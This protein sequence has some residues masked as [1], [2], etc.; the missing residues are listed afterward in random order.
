MAGILGNDSSLTSKA[1]E[2]AKA[3]VGEA[4]QEE[5]SVPTAQILL[6]DLKLRGINPK[7]GLLGIAEAQKQG[8]LKMWRK[9]NT[10]MAVVKISPIVARVHFFTVDQEPQFQ[11]LVK[12][13]LGSLVKSG[14]KVIYDRVADPHIIR[15][16][17]AAGAHIVPSDTPNMKLKAFI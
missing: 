14:C 4:P 2:L 5:G 9:D 17:Q 12:E 7:L 6:S 16:L 13:F 3:V 15:A 11:A 10:I 8:G 1:Q